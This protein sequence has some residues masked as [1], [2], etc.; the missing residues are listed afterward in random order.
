MSLGENQT[1]AFRVKRIFL[2][3]RGH[4]GRLFSAMPEK[5]DSEKTREELLDEVRQARD[6][7]EK[8]VRERTAALTEALRGMESEV[9][10]R[11]AA[12]EDLKRAAALAWEERAKS[13]AIIAALGDGI[14]IQD[15]EFRV[16]FQN[17]A[18][19]DLV[20]DHPGE[21]CYRAYQRQEEICK[22][23]H[24]AQSFRDGLVHKAEQCR[25]TDRGRIYYDITVSPLRDAGGRIVAGIEIVRDIT[26]RK[27]AEAD[28][29][30]LIAELQDAL[31][32]IRT[33][34]G[35]LP[36][37]AWCKRIRDDRGYWKQVE[38]YI[39]KHSDARFTHGICPECLGKVSPEV[40]ENPGF[41]ETSRPEPGRGEDDEA[42]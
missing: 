11:E 20:G 40:L 18:H 1:T 31:A 19:K 25:I 28:Q 8:Q 42:R 9:A 32:R 33:L 7:M 27:E 34:N 37:C 12:E 16:L 35:L 13:E 23:C 30:R 41:N 10:R 39:E 26:W 24:L 38:S 14:S 15:T 17:Q 22:G 3:T 29:E 5:K 2:T 6:A 36:I 4:G 21:Y